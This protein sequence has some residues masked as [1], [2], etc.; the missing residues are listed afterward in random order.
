MRELYL[1]NALLAIDH[2]R[3]K[4][5]LGAGNI[6]GN[7]HVNAAA[8][9]VNKA[10]GEAAELIRAGASSPVGAIAATAK[11]EGAGNC[12]EQAALAFEYLKK[13]GISPIEVW[14][15]DPTRDDH[16]FVVIGRPATASAGWADN[17][18][19]DAVFCDPWYNE[20]EAVGDNEDKYGTRLVLQRRWVRT[21]AVDF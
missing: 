14:A 11:V 6:P 4:L 7:P 19:G 2:V 13:I 8:H 17:T 3:T 15:I 21:V 16:A 1:R 20:A 10:R 5:P 9:A 12:G 18:W